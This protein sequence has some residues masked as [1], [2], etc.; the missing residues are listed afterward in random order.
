MNNPL[1]QPLF[2]ASVTYHAARIEYGEDS[3]EA[4]AARSDMYVVYAQFLAHGGT[5]TEAER[6]IVEGHLQAVMNTVSANIR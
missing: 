1:A 6:I 5:R 3:G 2:N 4:E